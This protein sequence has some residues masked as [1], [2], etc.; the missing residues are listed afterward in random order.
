MEK[1]GSMDR[2]GLK[3]GKKQRKERCTRIIHAPVCSRP[4]GTML[5][6]PL[7]K[8]DLG[9]TQI[10]EEELLLFLSSLS[11]GE[12]LGSRYHLLQHNCNNFSQSLAQF[13]TGA[14][15]PQ[16]I[17]DLPK[18][19]MSSPIASVLGPI[20]EQATPTGQ[21]QTFQAVEQEKPTRE[22]TKHFPHQVKEGPRRGKRHVS[23]RFLAI[24]QEYVT[25][26]QPIARD[27]IQ[28]KFLEL[29]EKNKAEP[30]NDLMALTE[31]DMVLTPVIWTEIKYVR[32]GGRESLI[33]NIKR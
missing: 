25:F 14:N 11:T 27:K 21:G 19:V 24:L 31:Q 18:K 30:K 13:L 23:K 10:S 8:I 32:R 15:I 6:Q 26:R 29:C 22:G 3:D 4:G 9:Q 20:M 5:G 16:H 7:Q 28:E 1:N 33:P 2:E 17:L 12:Y